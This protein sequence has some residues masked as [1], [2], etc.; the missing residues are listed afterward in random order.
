MTRNIKI[1]K[2][3]VRKKLNLINVKI[4]NLSNMTHFVIIVF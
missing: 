1:K 4:V 2:I 3:L